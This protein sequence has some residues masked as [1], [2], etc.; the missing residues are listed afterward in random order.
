L[1]GSATAAALNRTH[2]AP[3]VISHGCWKRRNFLKAEITTCD[4]Y[5]RQYDASDCRKKYGAASSHFRLNVTVKHA[6]QLYVAVVGGGVASSLQCNMDVFSNTLSG[7]RMALLG[8]IRALNLNFIAQTTVAVSQLQPGQHLLSLVP[9]EVPGKSV[10]EDVCNLSS[11]FCV[12]FW[13]KNRDA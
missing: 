11:I 2:F 7:K 6:C 9:V 12:P 3:H 8:Q 4:R 5:V 13:A 10:K 1:Q